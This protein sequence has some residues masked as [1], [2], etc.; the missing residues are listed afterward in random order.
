MAGETP[1]EHT[2]GV[3]MPQ[4][5]AVQPSLS[6]VQIAGVTVLRNSALS[7]LKAACGYLQVSQSGSK[8][9]LWER[10]LA[11]LDKQAINAERELASM[12]LDETRRKADAGCQAPR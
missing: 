6:S 4:T 12:A 7:V 2:D 10:I 11:T 9:K 3:D 8:K 5:I 1:V